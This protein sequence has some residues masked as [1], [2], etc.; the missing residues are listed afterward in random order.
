[1]TYEQL[2]T[3]T[4]QVRINQQ[5]KFTFV[6]GT[7]IQYDEDLYGVFIDTCAV[8]VDSFSY[9]NAGEQ[10]LVEYLHVIY[11]WHR[12]A[13]IEMTPGDLVTLRPLSEIFQ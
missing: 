13:S 3:E 8:T 6:D 1:V 5:R 2:M 10:P 7:S 12:I 4:G 11:P 9:R